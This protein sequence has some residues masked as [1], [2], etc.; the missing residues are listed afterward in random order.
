[1]KVAVFD[2]YVKKSDGNTAHFDIL[3]PEAKYTHDEVIAFGRQYL[4]SINEE[5]S[6]L[7]AKECRFCH[8][9]SPGPEVM[10]SI[11]EK[12]YFILE[13]ADISGHRG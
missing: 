11:E 1:M 10:Q 5:N 9:E 6:T 2:T 8:L 7:T 3:V 12:G 13:M 4:E